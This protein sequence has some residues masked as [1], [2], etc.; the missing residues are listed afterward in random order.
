MAALGGL[1]AYSD[2]ESDGGDGRSGGGLVAYTEEEDERQP[3]RA[4]A[5]AA[6]EAPGRDWI[7]PREAEESPSAA[8]GAAAPP[9][10]SPSPPPEAP[11]APD[12]RAA[13]AA[14]YAS[15]RLAPR[16]VGL[17]PAGASALPPLPPLPTE[18]GDPGVQAKVA[19]YLELQARGRS[20]NDELRRSKGYRN[21]CFLQKIAEHFG[22][23]ERGTELA[24]A[25]FDPARL[26]REDYYDELLAQLQADSERRDAERAERAAKLQRGEPVAAVQFER[27][28]QEGPSADSAAAA[29]RAAAA[30]VSAQLAEKQALA[31]HPSQPLP[32]RPPPPLKHPPAAGR[33]RQSRWGPN[34]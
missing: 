5:E 26:P 20:V 10:P 24:P 9:S 33:K 11:S 34:Q 32:F 19:R 17:A 16:V 6:A 21:P 23:D 7:P 28:G 12:E 25:V 14:A 4:A 18:P 2:S 29:A 22:I 30:A 8:P 15:G 13:A 31:Q 3:Q 1:L 27:G